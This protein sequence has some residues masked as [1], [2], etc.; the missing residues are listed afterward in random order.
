MDE[1]LDDS[2]TPFCDIKGILFD[3]GDTL[4]RPIGGN[5]W[6]G[7]R[8]REILDNY[9]IRDLS[10]SRMECALEEG[11]RYLDDHH[12]L[13]TV[14]EER[15]QFQTFYRIVLEHLGL[16]YHDTSLLSALA[17]ARV[18]E[19]DFEVYDDTPAVL[20]RLYKNG[21]SLG[22][23]SDAWP[24]LERKHRLLGLRSY[25]Q[26][27]V[28]SAQ[29]GCCKPDER[30]YKRAIDELRLPPENLLFVDDVP[31]NVEKAI[32]LGL[33]G[34][35]MVRNGIPPDVDIEWVKNL[36]EIEARL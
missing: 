7:A 4:V 11:I 13:M 3:S 34:V 36:E 26:T 28:I 32:E 14:D 33:R 5:W 1:I 9:N 31:E 21:L 6:P 12:H 22:V 17:R 27:F 24:S 19:V 10:W 25:F 30:I 35:L 16:H 15:D 20:E 23:I 2:M 18:D 8:F 29:I